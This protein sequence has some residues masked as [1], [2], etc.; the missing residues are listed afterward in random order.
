M[1]KRLLLFAIC[2]LPIALFAQTSQTGSDYIAKRIQLLLSNAPQP[3]TNA[4]V[5]VSGNPGPATYYYWI[6][7]QTSVGASSPA[8]PF[9]AINAPNTLSV[10]NFN[11]ISWSTVSGAT[12]DVLRTSN[13]GPP[14]GACNCAVATGIAVNTVNDQANSLNAYTVNT[15]DPSTQTVTLQNVNGTFSVPAN[16]SVGGTLNG[17]HW[18]TDSTAGADLGAKINTAAA[19]GGIVLISPGMVATSITTALSLPAG[20]TLYFPPGNFNIAAGNTISNN[21]ISIIGSGLGATIWKPTSSTGDIFT[22]SGNNFNIG[23]GDVLPTVTRTSGAFMNITG[24]QGKIHDLVLH[25]TWDGFVQGSGASQNAFERIVAEGGGGNWH[26]VFR[27]GPLASGTIPGTV[28]KNFVIAITSGSGSTITGPLF[29]LDSGTDS[30][31]IDGLEISRITGI[32]TNPAFLMQSTGAAQVPSYVVMTNSY[33]ETNNLAT[34]MEIDNAA[35]PDFSNLGIALGIVGLKITGGKGIKISNSFFNDSQQGAVQITGGSDIVFTGNTINDSAAAAAN[36]YDGISVAA[37][38]SKFNITNNRIG[39]WL[40]GGNTFRN[41][42]S[43]AAGASDQYVILGNV[44]DGV[45]TSTISDGGTGIKKQVQDITASVQSFSPAFTVNIAGTSAF[46]SFGLH[47]TTPAAPTP[48]K[49]FRITGGSL[50]IINSAFGGVIWALDDSGNESGIASMQTAQ[51]KTTTNCAAVGTAASPSVASCGSAAA[52]HF[53]CATNA[54]GATCQV[55]TTAVT[56][57]SEIFVFESDTAVTGTAL[58]VTCNTSTTVNPATRLLASSV[59][60][61]SFTINLGTVTTNPACFS[62]HIVN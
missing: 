22:I 7:A 48:N 29:V 26:T 6:I 50:N 33:C 60:G 51:Y 11:Q 45:G 32:D 16:V 34:C 54:T 37:G 36:T 21:G 5:S 18:V 39:N 62:Y 9:A 38:V 35:L 47:D 13:T 55:N 30:T 41:G 44:I 20:T 53:S 28:I 19:S 12:Y 61:A 57:N 17:V 2:Y 56:A 24:G 59:A 31:K 8:G 40:F 46:G 10:S 23:G 3:V 43:V 14:F 27:N 15:F 52:G 1:M 4:S 49:F 58:G 25:D 42:I